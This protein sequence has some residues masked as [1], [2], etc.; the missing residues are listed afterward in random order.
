MRHDTVRLS[1]GTCR[2]VAHR[3]L[4]GLETENTCAA[5][6]AAGLRG[7][8]GIETDVHP[9]ADGRF[10][11]CHDA[12]L[13]RVSGGTSLDVRKSALAEAQAGREEGGAGVL[14]LEAR[15]PAVRDEPARAG[16]ELDGVFFHPWWSKALTPSG[17]ERAKRP[18]RKFQP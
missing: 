11:C 16:R 18:R 15:E 7:Y 10:V 2:F 12:D 6:L 3:G 13:R 5:F 8:W 9:T 14:G 1:S 17:I 4:S